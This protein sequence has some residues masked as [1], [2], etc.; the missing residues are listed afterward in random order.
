MIR[1]LGIAQ[2]AAKRINKGSRNRVQRNI[3][4]NIRINIVNFLWKTGKPPSLI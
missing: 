3:R 1:T 4:R 2:G